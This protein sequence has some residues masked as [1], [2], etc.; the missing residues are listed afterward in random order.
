MRAAR[1]IGVGVAALATLA[2]SHARAAAGAAFAETSRVASLADAVTARPGDAGTIELNPAGL[3]DLREASVLAGGHADYVSQWFQRTGDPTQQDRSRAFGG[4]FIAAAT[5]LPGPAWARRIGVGLSLDMP[6]QY[7]LHLDIPVR[8]DQ[9]ISPT[10]DSRPDRLAGAFAIGAKV[11]RWLDFGAGFAFTPSLVEPALITYQAGRAPDV[12]GNVEVRIDTT[13]DTGVSPF[14]GLRAK[15]LDWL[16]FSLVYREAQISRATGTQTTTAAGITA[17]GPFNFYQMWD[18]AT[19]VVGTAMTLSRHVSFSLDVSW[20]Q[21]SAIHDG[22]DQ[23]LPGP[24][25]FHDTVN[26]ASGVEIS[27]PKGVALRGG[28]AVEP[29]PMPEQTGETN[30]LGANALTLALGAGIDFRRLARVPLA[31]DLHF[32]ARADALESAVKDPSSLPD[33]DGTLPGNQIDNMGYP[34]FRSQALLVQGGLT[35]TLFIGGGRP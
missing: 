27:L 9:P 29:S 18:P 35:A 23:P 21:W 33:A 17:A 3:G 10:Y 22:F 20:E 28:V 2:S 26:V 5:P 7:L 13:L 11:V 34:S 15:P 25:Q 19:V 16:A 24:I 14:V 32:R 31:I 8:A 4:V 30:Y 6:V 12:N 1:V